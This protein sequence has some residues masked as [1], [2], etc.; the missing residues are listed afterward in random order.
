MK[1]KALLITATVLA[2]L[3]VAPA[4]Q[5][6]PQA[7]AA[8]S[9]GLAGYYRSLGTTYVH[10]LTVRSITCAGGRGLVRSYN[11]C[12]KRRGGVRGRC[13]SVSGYSCSE[14]RNTSRYQFDAT[15]SCS[16]GSKRFIVSY[17]QNT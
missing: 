1:S 2:A 15:A 8:A 6:A 14:F 10:R 13:P 9:C 16:R 7:S 4:T 3:A 11:A 17:T 5:A 12:R